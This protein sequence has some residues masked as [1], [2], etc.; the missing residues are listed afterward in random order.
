MKKRG[1]I[2]PLWRR[3]FAYIIDGLIIGVIVIYP[4]EKY[5]GKINSLSFSGDLFIASIVIA[6]L[7]VFYW[8]I[9]EYSMRQS[10]GKMVFGIYVNAPKKTTLWPFVL[11]NLTKVSSFT[12][13]LDVLYMLIT[14][15]HQRY[16]EKMSNTEVLGVPKRK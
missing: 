12:L 1:V 13:G 7:T 5:F 11:R 4:F 3:V 9:L 8:A 2:A 6:I 10:I 15:Q 14:R 16:F